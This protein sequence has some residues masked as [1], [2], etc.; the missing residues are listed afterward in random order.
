LVNYSDDLLLAL[1]YFTLLRL[2]QDSLLRGMHV[3]SFR[4]AWQ[5]VDGLPGMKHQLNPFYNFIGAI[6]LDDNEQVVD[7]LESLRVF[8]LDMK[9]NRDTIAGYQNKF[10]FGFDP[11]P[12]SR[13]PVAGLAVPMDRRKKQ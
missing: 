8:P 9:W 10:G 12:S 3:N 6:F 1:A 7:G 4:R 2:E 11:A 5:G 13:P